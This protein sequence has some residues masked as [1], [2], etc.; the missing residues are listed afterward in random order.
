[1]QVMFEE[2]ERRGQIRKTGEYRNGRP[3]YVPTAERKE[4]QNDLEEIRNL[5]RV[6]MDETEQMRKAN[7]PP[8]DYIG[9]RLY[10][11]EMFAELAEHYGV[12]IPPSEIERHIELTFER[13]PD[14]K[15]FDGYKPL[16][17]AGAELSEHYEEERR[18]R[19]LAEAEGRVFPTRAWTWKLTPS[20]Q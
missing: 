9:R 17:D 4:G 16:T 19:K 2:L 11:L 13:R 14:G 15:W 8:D 6:L 20:R 5:V 18:Q 7:P 12:A 10:H 3:V 1:M